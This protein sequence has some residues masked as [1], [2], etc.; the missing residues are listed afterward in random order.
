MKRQSGGHASAPYEGGSGVIGIVARLVVVICCLAAIG[1]LIQGLRQPVSSLAEST[2][3]QTLASPSASLVPTAMPTLSPMPSQTPTP[4]LTSTPAAPRV[5]LV[6]GHWGNDTGAVCLDDGLKEVDINL[7]VAQR[8]EALLQTQGYTVD[9]M[10]EFD[11]L[12]HGYEADALVSI[13]ADS[14]VDYPDATPPASGFKVAS[15]QESLVPEEERRL[16]ECLVMH[17]GEQTGMFYHENSVTP[18]MS[19]YHA[20]YEISGWTPGAIIETGFMLRDR[21]MLTNHPELVA[22]GI[23]D[24]IICFVGE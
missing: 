10:E 4:T 16:V 13:H 7:D 23:A 20:F 2:P 15:V 3:A 18:H 6:V 19:R 1:S 22:R 5:G 21:E 12:L 8:V 24:G 17:Y 11:D 9:L 14:C